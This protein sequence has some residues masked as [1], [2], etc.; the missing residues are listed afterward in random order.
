M[1]THKPS[2]LEYMDEVIF[3]ANGKDGS[4]QILWRYKII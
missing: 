3:L 4:G 1:V 2:D